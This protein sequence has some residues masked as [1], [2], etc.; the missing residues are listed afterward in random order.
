MT[1]IKKILFL[2]KDDRAQAAAELAIF[3]AILVFVIG[4]IVRT[5][6]N[7]GVAENA[8]LRALRYALSESYR[9]SER[10]YSCRPSG[11]CHD[12]AARNT[13][14]IVLVEDR[15]S[16]NSGQKAGTRDRI[17]FVASASGVMSHNLFL[18][19]ED[20]ESWS[21][22]QFDMI[23]NGQRF[24]FR[25]TSIEDIT[26]SYD[27]FNQATCPRTTSENEPDPRCWETVCVKSE[28]G[29]TI[30]G[31][32]VVY[33]IATN[34]D[35]DWCS[36]YDDSGNFVDCN[37][38]MTSDERFDLD[39][40]NGPDISRIEQG[41]DG[42]YVR[43]TFSWQWIK[44]PVVPPER[45]RDLVLDAGVDPDDQSTFIN[46]SNP[47]RYRTLAKDMSADIDGNL[48]EETVNDHIT[49]STPGG[50][51]E[52]TVEVFYQHTGDL[53]LSGREDN[54]TGLQTEE[55][56]MYSFTR[57][58]DNQTT[59][60]KGTYLRIE[61]GQLFGPGGQFIRS[62]TRQDH[63]DIVERKIVF[64]STP[65]CNYAGP[66]DMFCE[67]DNNCNLIGPREW[68]DD[69]ADEP[70]RWSVDNGVAGLRNP[71]E[72]CV[73]PP[74]TIDAL[75]PCFSA[76]NPGNIEKTCLQIGDADHNPA[77]FVRSRIHDLRGHRWVTR[78]R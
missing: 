65:Y 73:S 8:H 72:V 78:L 39:F 74:P 11:P 14:N 66:V 22:S 24:P 33:R 20:S 26:L 32:P 64:R 69:V 61:E 13:A 52:A 49:Y 60:G 29:Q 77:I 70:T 23:I 71:V 18:P 41:S 51:L 56:Q 6:L 10:E 12:S 58:R 47:R 67:F 36:G 75:H 4:L 48:E 37:R 68:Y 45:V 44:V 55:L 62:T 34:G 15:L 63:V 16:V 31:C 21:Q 2:Q 54:N 46:V 30:E 59:R 53:D 17:P 43:E 25:M 50:R 76:G 35:S 27:M 7:A 19:V 5:G 28:N 42:N 57:N 1:R 3:G 40:R 38:N 9:S